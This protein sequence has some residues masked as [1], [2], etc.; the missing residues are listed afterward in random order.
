MKKLKTN[1]LHFQHVTGLCA[2]DPDGAGQGMSAWTSLLDRILDHLQR[3]RYFLLPNAC[4]NTLGKVSIWSL[5][6]AEK[7]SAVRNV[8]DCCSAEKT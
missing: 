8:P 3:V 2:F 6:Q 5:F 1:D 7:L 4:P